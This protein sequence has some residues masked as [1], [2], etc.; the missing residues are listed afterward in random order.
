M[1]QSYAVLSGHSIQN[2]IRKTGHSRPLQCFYFILLLYDLIST[3]LC[4]LYYMLF[5]VMC[6]IYFF[7]FHNSVKFIWSIC[8]TY[9]P[10][11]HILSYQT[12][13]IVC[14]NN[15]NLVYHNYK[16]HFY[17]RNVNHSCLLIK[18]I[19]ACSV[20]KY[21][22]LLG[23]ATKASTTMKTSSPLIWSTYI[24]SYQITLNLTLGQMMKQI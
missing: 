1:P 16:G 13:I 18:L 5:F 21:V 11:H 14:I 8:I 3:T 15:S 9:L 17:K 24:S 22:W 20:M 2:I 23:K 7:L 4:M 12:C 10:Q 6:I 19:Y